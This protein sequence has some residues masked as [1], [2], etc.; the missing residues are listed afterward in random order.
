MADLL[1]TVV[2]LSTESDEVDDIEGDN[3]GV[4]L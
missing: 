1:A 2:V 4:G 3:I